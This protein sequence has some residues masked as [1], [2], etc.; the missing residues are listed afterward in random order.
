[1]KKS[2]FAFLISFFSFGAVSTMADTKEVTLNQSFSELD[3]SAGVNVTY[4]PSSTRNC[5][6]TLTGNADKIEN[7]DIRIKG[8]A[9]KISPKPDNKGSRSGDKI[10]GVKITVTAPMVKEINASSGA[11]LNCTALLSLRSSDMDLDVSSGASIKLTEI[12]CREM[13]IDASSGGTVTIK[14]LTATEAELD[15]SSGAVITVSKSTT[16]NIDCEASSG[17]VINV[18]GK[19]TNGKFSASSGGAVKA[20]SLTV[21]N[22]KVKKAISGSVN[23]NSER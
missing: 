6:V 4:N 9:L 19:S 11:Q 13:E 1:M 16:D 8:D 3:L 5:V 21:R 12:D 7:V 15:A 17:G 22:S 14:N 23:V 20:S 18:A 10:R 2:L